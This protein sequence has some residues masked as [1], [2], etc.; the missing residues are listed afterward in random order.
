VNFATEVD[1]GEAQSLAIAKHRG[2]VFL[3]DDRKAVK[4]AQRPDVAVRTTSTPNILQS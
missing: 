4:V 3:T 1:D 2:F